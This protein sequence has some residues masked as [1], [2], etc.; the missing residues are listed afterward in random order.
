M[1]DSE[2]SGFDCPV[3]VWLIY[4]F[5]CSGN[6]KSISVIMH[7]YVNVAEIDARKK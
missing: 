2:D 5:L 4:D 3:S 7:I 6:V 1:P